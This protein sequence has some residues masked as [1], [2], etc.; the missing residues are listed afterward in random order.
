MTKQPA[1]TQKRTRTFNASIIDGHPNRCAIVSPTHSAV[2]PG[3]ASQPGG[4]TAHSA[5]RMSEELAPAGALSN[6][7][8]SSRSTIF[9]CYY[10][11]WAA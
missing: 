10:D 8:P 4:L 9:P 2:P 5:L 7:R 3:L 11:W 1:A 6:G